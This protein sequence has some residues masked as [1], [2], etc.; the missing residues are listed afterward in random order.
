MSRAKSRAMA[1][2]LPG[3]EPD[4]PRD[5]DR[6][7]ERAIDPYQPPR[8]TKWSIGERAGMRLALIDVAADPLQPAAE[9]TV[10]HALGYLTFEQLGQVAGLMTSMVAEK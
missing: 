2:V 3:M 4:E 7:T 9:L 1:D 6:P 5:E 10:A 8:R